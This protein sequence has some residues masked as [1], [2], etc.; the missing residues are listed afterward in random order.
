MPLIYKKL[1]NCRY[2]LLA[3]PIGL[4]N[5]NSS[6]VDE[7]VHLRECS[8]DFSS[9]NLFSIKNHNVD[10]RSRSNLAQELGLGIGNNADIVASNQINPFGRLTNNGHIRPNRLKSLA[11]RRSPTNRDFSAHFKSSSRA[12]DIVNSKNPRAAQIRHQCGRD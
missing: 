12:F 2:S 9:D 8:T 6:T 5:A 11:L 10:F 1:N 7:H 4:S 3:E